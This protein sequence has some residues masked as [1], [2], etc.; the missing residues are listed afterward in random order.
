MGPFPVAGEATWSNDWHAARCNPDP[1]LHKGIDIFAPAGTPLV[2]T[3]NGI[4]TQKGIG[5]VSGLHVEITGHRGIQYF[6]AHLSR[7]APDLALGQRVSRGDV[8]GF[9]GTTGNARGTSPHVHLEVQPGGVPVA[10]KPFVD[11]WIARAELEA[12]RWVR[13]VLSTP[14]TPE[15]EPAAEASRSAQPRW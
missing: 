15:A 3:R 7:F 2:A 14:T 4:V 11:R 9:V 12:T 13:S 6:Y 1:H 10:P 5:A 8:V